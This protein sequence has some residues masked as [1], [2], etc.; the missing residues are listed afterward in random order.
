M[1]SF[2]SSSAEIITSPTKLDRQLFEHITNYVNQ[3]SFVKLEAA[4]TQMVYDQFKSRFQQSTDADKA[5]LE[6]QIEKFIPS[7]QQIKAYLGGQ[8][9]CYRCANTLANFFQ[10]SYTLINHNPVL[11]IE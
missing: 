9:L 10:I 7:R 4:L 8:P 1:T 3:Y 2:N 5:I 11:E 6:N